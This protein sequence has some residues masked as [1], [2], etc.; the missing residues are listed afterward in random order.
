M[1]DPRNSC[2]YSLVSTHR[3]IHTWTQTRTHVHIHTYIYTKPKISL[4]KPR[5]NNRCVIGKGKRVILGTNLWEATWN[6]ASL[7]TGIRDQLQGVKEQVFALKGRGG[8]KRSH[9]RVFQIIKCQPYACK[10]GWAPPL[11]GKDTPRL[12]ILSTKEITPGRQA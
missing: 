6:R 7:V 2:W 4:D 12:Q 10:E 5:E 11:L 3:H 8:A 1:A 9:I